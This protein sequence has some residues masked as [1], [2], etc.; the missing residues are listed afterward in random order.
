[1]CLAFALIHPVSKYIVSASYTQKEEKYSYI[2]LV[3]AVY[4]RQ[5]KYL[6]AVN[7]VSGHACI[8]ARSGKHSLEKSHVAFFLQPLVTSR[9]LAM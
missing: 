9:M 8:C 7:I 3:A 1:M 6:I 4:G 2:V 5:K